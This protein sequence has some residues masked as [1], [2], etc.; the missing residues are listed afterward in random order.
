MEYAAGTVRLHLPPFNLTILTCQSWARRL[1]RE[2]RRWQRRD[3]SPLRGDWEV[4]PELCCHLSSEYPASNLRVSSGRAQAHNV[5]SIFQVERCG[6]AA[7]L[8][9]RVGRSDHG[10]KESK[11]SFSLIPLARFTTA[12][13][14]HFGNGT[15][16]VTCRPDAVCSSCTCEI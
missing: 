7:H 1:S 8:R 10:P 6:K 2:R 15:S 3:R 11:A 5:D 9:R 12:G 16:R 13:G 14:T 4:R